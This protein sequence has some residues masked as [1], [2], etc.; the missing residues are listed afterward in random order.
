M[1]KKT[2]I[3]CAAVV[4]LSIV[5]SLSNAN[6][7]GGRSKGGC[8]GGYGGSFEGMFFK[9]AH[10]ILENEEAIGLS[11]E[12]AAAVKALKLETKKA[13]IKQNAEIEVV[14]L[15][16]QKELHT[17]PVNAEALGKLVDQ[18][19]DLKKAEAK[20]LVEAIAQLKGTLSKDQYEK[21]RSLK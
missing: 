18:K 12:K 6:A 15:D 8:G 21:L 5:I 17:Y 14:S 1:K 19:Y 11:V 3:V 13:L 20:G 4:L 2:G 9:K 16:I 7:Y 10:F